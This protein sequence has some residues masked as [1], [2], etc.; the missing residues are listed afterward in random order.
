MEG[1][2]L[3]A[4]AQTGTGKTAAYL[5]PV[6]NMLADGGYPEGLYDSYDEYI[7][8]KTDISLKLF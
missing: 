1:N 7:F 5:L 6:I 3:L 8:S 4:C 2:D